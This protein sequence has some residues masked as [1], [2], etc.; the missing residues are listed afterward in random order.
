MRSFSAVILSGLVGFAGQAFGANTPPLSNAWNIAPAGKAAASGELEFRITTDDGSNPV[1]IS[2]PVIAGTSEDGIA[3][4][5]RRA[6]SSQLR[7]D[8]FNVSLGE[9]ANVLVTDQRG[10]PSFSLELT[11]SGVE[12]VRVTVQS[13][14]PVAPPTVPQQTTPANPPVQPPVTPQAPGDV[15][16]PNVPAPESQPGAQTPVTP[17]APPPE[18]STPPAQPPASAPPAAPPPNATGGAG[19]PA[20]APPPGPAPPTAH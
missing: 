14:A 4:N 9:G 7:S 10:K 11:D 5:I 3:R 12:N 16:P 15:V 1:D 13:V 6:L 17:P 18:N 19:A 20:S 2:V 8:R